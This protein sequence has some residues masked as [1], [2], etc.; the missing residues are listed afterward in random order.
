MPDLNTIGGIHY[1]MMRRCYNEKSIAYKDYGA[2]GITVCLEWHDRETFKQWA[3]SNGYVKGLRLE[4]ID[5]SG[6]YE[7]DNCCFG[8]S[9]K[10]KSGVGQKTK[11]IM[12]HRKIMKEYADIHGNY[13]NTRLYRIYSG[14][15]IRCENER[16][17][18][19]RNYGGRGID[20]CPEWS[21][22]DGFFYFYKW[23][24]EN[25]YREELSIDRV[26]N[27]KGYYPDNCRW[28]TNK[29][30]T[31]N[32]RT[33][34]LYEYNGKMSNLSDIAKQV[35]ITYGKLYL[36]VKNKGMTVYEAIK[37]VKSKY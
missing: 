16:D 1:D 28:A 29:I 27:D 20:V 3:V 6:N 10:R 34:K 30:Q 17:P 35:G 33:S 32:K 25:G 13:S 11:R 37:D 4:R 9:M 5:C 15:H 19:Y 24:M 14:M 22:K 26:D 8:K 21:G 31:D 12:R 2:R 18:H 7:P 23:A 36:R